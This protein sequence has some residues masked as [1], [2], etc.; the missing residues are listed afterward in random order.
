[1]DYWAVRINNKIFKIKHKDPIEACTQVIEL[2]YKKNID[3]TIGS[4]IEATKGKTVK[5]FKSDVILAN[6]GKYKEAK[7]VRKFNTKT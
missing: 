6:A 5:Y 1:M 3:F 7:K 2:L 4:L